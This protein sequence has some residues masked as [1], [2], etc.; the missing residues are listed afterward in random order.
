MEGLEQE[1]VGLVD[2]AQN[3]LTG[4]AQFLEESDNVV[5]ALAVETRGR[6]VQEQEQV[7][8][9][10]ELDTDSH[11]LTGFHAEAE[12]GHTNH[13]VGEV[14]QLEQFDNI[15]TVGILFLD[16]DGLRLTKVG[17]KAECFTDSSGPLV[18]I[19]SVSITSV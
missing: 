15:F 5:G 4:V 10:G 2:G 11:S 12:T 7:G 19:L 3:F 8:L 17:R 6:L 18:N 14:L 16:G 13:G 9:G 1:R